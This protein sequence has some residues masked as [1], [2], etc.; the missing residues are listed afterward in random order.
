[1]ARRTGLKDALPELPAEMLARLAADRQ[2][3]GDGSHLTATSVE[4]LSDHWRPLV[5]PPVAGEE[6]VDLVDG[7][8]HPTGVTAPRWLCHLLGLCHC[9]VHVILRTPQDLLVFQVRSRHVDWPGLLDLSVT[10]HVRAGLGWLEAAG[11]EAAE[12]LGIDFDPAAD[13]LG[14][15]GLRPVGDPYVRREAD[16]ENPPVHICHL[17]QIY[18]ATLTPAGLASL[19]FADGEVDALYLCSEARARH[20]LVHEPHR[21]AP[22]FIQS[23]PRYLDSR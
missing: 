21:L 4:Q 22:G 15:P 3:I 19:R 10:G 9:T 1:M 17:T 6:L 23:L 16:S 11:Q 12:E 14:P 7:S 13:H 2:A 5:G 20:L 18:A 8:G